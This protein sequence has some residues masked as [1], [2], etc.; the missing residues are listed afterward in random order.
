M[1]VKSYMLV[2]S[3]GQ[4]LAIPSEF[5]RQVVPFDGLSPLPAARGTLLGLMA[6]TGRAVPVLDVKNVLGTGGQSDGTTPEA[7]RE[8]ESDLAEPLALLLEV[9]DA[10]LTLPVREVIGFITDEEEVFPAGSFVSEEK[11]L[12][13]YSGGG[14]NGRFVQPQAL[15]QQVSGR[16][17]GLSS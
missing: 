16:L 11:L 10:L 2:R 5:T 7:S 8:A 6:A 15:V 12:G 17:A 9:G 1:A 14:H 3:S 13:G 4:I